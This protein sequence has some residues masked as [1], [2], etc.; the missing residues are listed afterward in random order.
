MLSEIPLSTLI[1][2]SFYLFANLI[3]MFLYGWD[4]Q[5]AKRRA[6]RIS[7]KTLLMWT[8]MSGG[9]IA[10]AAQRVLRHKTQKSVFQIIAALALT[11]HIT[12]WIWL[13]NQ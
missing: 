3:C 6:P 10:L 5:A 1:P 9:L 4:K 7:E 8:L 2:S 12:V 11:L 13:L